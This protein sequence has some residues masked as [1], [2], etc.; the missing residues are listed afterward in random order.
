M[1]ICFA[2]GDRQERAKREYY[3]KYP[4]VVLELFYMD[5]S[6]RSMYQELQRDYD[7]KISWARSLGLGTKSASRLSL[8]FANHVRGNCN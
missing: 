7:R 4:N 8:I 1:M 5:Q 6:R 3:E 2:D